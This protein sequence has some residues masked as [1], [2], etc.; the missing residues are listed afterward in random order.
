MRVSSPCKDTGR[1]SR[2]GVR[3]MRRA[4]RKTSDLQSYA[5]NIRPEGFALMYEEVEDPP[6]TSPRSQGGSVD[7]EGSGA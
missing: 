6:L 5:F 2:G 7:T 3:K 1:S 4:E